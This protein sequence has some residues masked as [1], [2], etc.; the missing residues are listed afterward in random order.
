[1]KLTMN[2]AIAVGACV[3]FNYAVLRPWLRRR[4][5][6]SPVPQAPVQVVAGAVCLGV[7]AASAAGTTSGSEVLAVLA[8]FLATGGVATAWTFRRTR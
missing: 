6:G 1:M 8:F 4:F 7:V 2:V 3:L 5:Q